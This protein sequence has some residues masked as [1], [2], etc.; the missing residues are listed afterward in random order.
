M[1]WEQEGNQLSLSLSLTSSNS[2][3]P[4]AVNCSFGAGYLGREIDHF[5]LIGA[6]FQRQYHPN[7]NSRLSLGEVTLTQMVS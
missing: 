4:S 5:H 6:A 7:R 2:F 1:E 3:D